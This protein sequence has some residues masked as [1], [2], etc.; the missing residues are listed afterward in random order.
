MLISRLY[1]GMG[2]Q[3]F[4]YAFGRA[5]S[6]KLNSKLTLDARF[7][8]ENKIRSNFTLRKFD[9]DLFNINAIIGDY[10][11]LEYIP[12]N[13]S[14]FQKVLQL[15]KCNLGIKTHINGY[16]LIKEEFY[17]AKELKEGNNYILDGYWQRYDYFK[18][19]EHLLKQELTFKDKPT[20]KILEIEDYI[21]DRNSIAI[22]IRKTDYVNITKNRMI[23]EELTSEYFES[24]LNFLKKK[25]DK[26]I[27]LIFSD[28]NN[29]AKENLKFIK[30]EKI[31]IEDKWKGDKYQYS[32][33][34]MNKSKN[35]IISN[36]SF[37][38]WG[39]FLSNYPEKIVVA[40]KNWFKI[41][42]KNNNISL[43]ASWVR[44]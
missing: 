24:S 23:F 19:I 10:D 18:D 41:P 29:W 12:H 16:R 5:I 38:W 36:S 42:S 39:A 27:I 11:N 28:D 22:Q 8:L 6:E 20:T 34:L 37:G 7:L 17:D 44:L 2:N 9:L 13:F 31:I 26:P 1:G 32:M 3:L 15:I 35:H 4:Q 43:P 21:K 14:K 40:P 33:Y 25:I 30:D